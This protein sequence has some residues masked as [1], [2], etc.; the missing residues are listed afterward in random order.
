MTIGLLRN[1]PLDLCRSSLCD[2]SCRAE[3]P[4]FCFN[5]SN[6]CRPRPTRTRFAE[7]IEAAMCLRSFWAF[8]GNAVFLLPVTA[9]FVPQTTHPLGLQSVAGCLEHQAF[10]PSSLQQ[11]QVSQVLSELKRDSSDSRSSVPV[12]LRSSR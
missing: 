11:A 2:E 9:V 5:Y 3:I 1:N 10:V 7:V 8:A 6:A 12:A 4:A